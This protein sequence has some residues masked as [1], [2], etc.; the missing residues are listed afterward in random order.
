MKYDRERKDNK[1]GDL[2]RIYF[3]QITLQ[4]EEYCSIILT[5]CKS[6]MKNDREREDNSESDLIR[7][8][9]RQ[10]TLQADSISF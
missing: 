7:I 3:R 2:F 8:Y 9:F 1:E 5:Y 10:M 6:L 4:D